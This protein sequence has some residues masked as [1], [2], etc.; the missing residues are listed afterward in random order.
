MNSSDS[1]LRAVNVVALVLIAVALV[2]NTCAM[3]RLE[4]QV[5]RQTK[6]LESGVGGGDGRASSGA[7]S[8][9][10]SA[11]S[12]GEAGTGTG[13]EAVGWGG[14]RAEILHVEGAAP[15]APLTLAQKPKPQGDWYVQRRPS[16]PS[17]LNYYATNEGETSILTGYVYGRLM[18]VD[19]DHPP[20]VEPSL[21]TSWEVSADKLT[22]TYHL[23]RGV[24]R[25]AG[26]SRQPT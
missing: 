15:G 25:T 18:A 12:A 1:W 21:A 24:Q 2:M 22:Y 5:I 4:T 16:A 13:L 3:D 14:R 19:I 23:R 7:S 17:T 9:A 8:G 20:K 11:A 10:T 6:A 26:P